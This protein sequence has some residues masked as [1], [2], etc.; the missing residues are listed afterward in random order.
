MSVPDAPMSL[1]HSSCKLSFHRA[2][3]DTASESEHSWEPQMA[4][5]SCRGGRR[6]EHSKVQDD[7]AQVA[8]CVVNAIVSKS[9][10][11]GQLSLK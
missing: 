9:Y 5:T 4:A 6:S 10:E 11:Q 8:P 7:L 2:S 1:K 3:S